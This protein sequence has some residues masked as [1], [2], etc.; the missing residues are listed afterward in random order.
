[1]R[2][3]T[4]SPRKRCQITATTS[5]TSDEPIFGA[6]R[7]EIA[8]GQGSCTERPHKRVVQAVLNVLLRVL[9]QLS[10][11]ACAIRG[12]GFRSGDGFRTAF[13]VACCCCDDVHAFQS[14]RFSLQG[15]LSLPIA[16]V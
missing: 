5:Y 13:H 7:Q 10:R 15:V 4:C 12:T 2:I 3:C 8:L 11:D 6:E 9:P 1:M 14:G 16:L